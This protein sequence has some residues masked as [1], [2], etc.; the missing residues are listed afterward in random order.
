MR[1]VRPF[2]LAALLADGYALAV[3]EAGAITVPAV[4]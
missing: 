3:D 2:A 1:R 4:D